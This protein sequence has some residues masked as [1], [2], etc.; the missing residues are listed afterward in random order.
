MFDIVKAHF[1]TDFYWHITYSTSETVRNFASDLVEPNYSDC[2][3]QT[4]NCKT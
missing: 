1:M 4:L 2:Y 3:P